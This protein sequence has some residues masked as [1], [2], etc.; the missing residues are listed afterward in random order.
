ME[1]QSQ[2]VDDQIDE[3]EEEDKVENENQD[4]ETNK[5][6]VDEAK[7]ADDHLDLIISQEISKDYI[8]ELF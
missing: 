5:T 6:E 3:G 1:I 2:V 4:I 7:E 8:H